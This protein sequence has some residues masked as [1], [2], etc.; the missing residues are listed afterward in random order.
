MCVYPNEIWHLKIIKINRNTNE[1]MNYDQNL[2]GIFYR[3][4]SFKGDYAV[5]RTKV[6]I[7]EWIIIR[8]IDS[9]SLN[10]CIFLW[11]FHENTPVYQ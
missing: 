11:I 1:T 8:F 4:A 2:S 7:E 9:K 6:I 5:G 10:E 3:L